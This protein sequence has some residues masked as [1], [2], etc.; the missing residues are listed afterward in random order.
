MADYV[1]SACSTADY[2]RSFFDD[3]HILCLEFHYTMDGEVHADDLY[4]SITPHEFYSRIKAGSQPTTSQ[5]SAGEYVAAW[6]PHLK[7]GR[8]VLHVTLSSGISGTH[9][10]ACV[11]AEQLM[12]AY[13]ERRVAVIDSLAASAGYGLLVEYMADLRDSGA[14][15]DELA[16]WSEDHKLN[17]N[18]WF[19][20][21]DLECL[22]RG[23][24]VSR[25]SA[26]IASALKICPLLN[27]DYQGRLIPREKIRTKKRAIH[28]LVRAMMEHVDDGPAYAGKCVISQSD[29]RA[30]AEEVARLI[31]EQIP[32]LA[33][34]IAIHDIGT[35]IG[36]H[37]GPGTVALFFM[38]DKR[39]D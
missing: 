17:L 29:C 13:P 1:L 32:A 6:E 12:A 2:P 34:R 37:T 11:A 26:L 35:V 10:A 33:G 21:S 23:G 15:F 20:V 25:T 14:G 9:N 31:G 24:R 7:A 8:D 28:A 39:V 16:A 22:K 5:V 3:R 36:A 30:D 18:H 27:V 38:G 19:F 4:A